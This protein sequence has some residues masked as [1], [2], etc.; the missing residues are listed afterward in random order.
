MTTKDEI[1]TTRMPQPDKTIIRLPDE[2]IGT[3]KNSMPTYQVPPPPPPK[4]K[5]ENK[6]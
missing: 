2:G 3:Q 6:D 4:I 5:P 1:K